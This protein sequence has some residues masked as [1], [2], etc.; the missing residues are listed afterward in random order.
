MELR[1]P[2]GEGFAADMIGGSWFEPDSKVVGT[3]KASAD[4][5]VSASDRFLGLEGLGEIERRPNWETGVIRSGSISLGGGWCG[6]E[7]PEPYPV[8][9]T[10]GGAK[11]YGLCISSGEIPRV[12]GS[13]LMYL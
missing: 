7:I 10:G 9:S 4:E 3:A 11:E 8:K 5:A 6:S 12:A 1:R 2:G 13:W